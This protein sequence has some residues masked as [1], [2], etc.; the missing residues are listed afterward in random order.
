MTVMEH[1]DRIHL[2]DHVVAADIGA[3]QSE[4]GRTQRL[5]FTLTVDLREA[6]TSRDDQVDSVLSYDVLVHAIST[7]LADQ[8][9]NLVETLAEKIAAEVL[10]HPRAAAITVCVEKLDRGPGAVGV[11]IHRRAGRV[12]VDRATLPAEVILWTPETPPPAGPMILVP[13][14]TGLPV[15]QGGDARRVALLALDQS[16]WSL[17]GQL[18]L[19]VAESQTEL[20]A[21]IR[22]RQPVIWAPTR[23]AADASAPA[24]PL[25]LA[26]WLAQRLGLDRV[27]M[28]LPTTGALPDPV[29]PGIAL[30]RLTASDPGQ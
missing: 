4:R 8:R 1:A 11:T 15:P 12:A 22:A 7:A 29:V 28:A 30:H 6:A 24:Q 20:D 13:P 16:A 10:A 25:H 23:L 27:A 14:Q 18:G 9:Y 3:F 26:C 5:R 21:A 2:R 17:A 19:E